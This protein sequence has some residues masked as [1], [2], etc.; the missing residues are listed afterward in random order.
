MTSVKKENSRGYLPDFKK[1]DEEE[2][3]SWTYPEWYSFWPYR[4]DEC[5]P[6]P[7][8]GKD[9]KYNGVFFKK[10]CCPPVT[11]WVALLNEPPTDTPVFN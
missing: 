8:K 1:T 4:K 9:F 11:D 5:K 6:K 3:S 10:N 2:N 7:S